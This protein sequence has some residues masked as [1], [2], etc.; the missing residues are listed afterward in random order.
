[1]AADPMLVDRRGPTDSAWVS[2]ALSRRESCHARPQTYV[3]G[4]FV[5]PEADRNAT[6]AIPGGQ[7][8]DTVLPFLIADGAQAEPGGGNPLGLLPA[9][10]VIV[11]MFYFLMIRPERRKQAAHRNLLQQLKKNDRVVTIGGIYGV[12]TNVQRDS[13]EVT[14]K[15]DEAANAKLR[16]TFG[17]VARV[18]S[19]EPSNDKST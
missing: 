11:V 1:M 19:D 8:I 14:I 9:L 3:Q 5:A 2:R 12:V 17:A 15:V 16:I 13:D 7:V 18:I 4:T 10:L 6:T